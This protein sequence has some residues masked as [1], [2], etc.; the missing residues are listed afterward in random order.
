ML[1]KIAK[2]KQSNVRENLSVE[3]S[4]R[5]DFSKKNVPNT[6]FFTVSNV[7]HHTSSSSRVKKKLLQ[8]RITLLGEFK[9]ITMRVFG[10]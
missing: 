8:E 5:C 9:R 3:I 6:Y 4:E 10:K 2:E 7:Y 1:H